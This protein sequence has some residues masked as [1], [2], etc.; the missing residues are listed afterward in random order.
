MP[1]LR[2]ALSYLCFTLLACSRNTDLGNSVESN[3]TSAQGGS[4]NG[5]LAGSSTTSRG[6]DLGLGGLSTSPPDEPVRQLPTCADCSYPKCESGKTTSISGIVRT[7]AKISPDPLYNAVVYLPGATVEP[8]KPGVSCERCGNVS[9]EPV[10]ATLSA[11]DGTFKIDDAPAGHDIALVVQ[12]GRWRRQVTLPEVVACQDNPLPE[13]LTRFPRNRSEGDIPRLALVTS[14]YDPEECILRK[15][16]ID[17]AEF[18]LPSEEGR[19]N[20][21]TGQGALGSASAPTGSEL[22][23]DAQV[24]AS[25]DMVLLPCASTP[26]DVY[27]GDQPDQ[28]G[29]AAARGALADYANAG[30][31]VFTTDLSFSWILSD[32][33]PFANVANWVARPARDDFYDTLDSS[34]DTSFP[35]G[36]ALADWLHGI[37]ATPTLGQ[38]TLHETFLRSLSVNPPT[39][40]WLY[41]ETPQSLQSFTFNTPID[42]PAEAQCGRAAYSSFHI[43]GATSSDSVPTFPEECDAAPLTPQER[44]LEFMLFD[45]ASCVQIDTGKPKPPVVVK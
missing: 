41:S 20:L 23:G 28:L 35:K 1:E 15:L 14:P 24:L 39:Q 7:P 4:S 18:T 25:Y 2:A 33:A 5:S 40:R 37:N 32:G 13:D 36:Q 21:F 12:M 6:P 42:T 8:F 11:S 26:E 19:V 29:S 17:D 3:A 22:W 34:I 45:L 31:R 10:A 38:I 16:G 44:V 9:G 30:G 27:P 43:A